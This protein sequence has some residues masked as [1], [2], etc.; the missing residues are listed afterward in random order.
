MRVLAKH[1]GWQ[2][3]LGSATSQT[4]GSSKYTVK[5]DDIIGERVLPA[6]QVAREG[7]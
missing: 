2:W 1:H 6:N 5:F 4:D 7:C 3:L